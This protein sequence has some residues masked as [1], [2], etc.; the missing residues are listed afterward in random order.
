[1]R[2][3]FRDND[4]AQL[5]AHPI[6][7]AIN[8]G[9]LEAG[10]VPPPFVPDPRR[11][12]AKDLG[13]VGAFSSVRGVELDAGDAALGDAFASGTVPIPWQEELLETG[14]FQELDVW[15]PPGTLPPDLDPTKAPAGGGARSATCGVL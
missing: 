13:E 12:Y 3:G 11:V 1:T 6:F 7:A 14:L 5:K 4:C 9:R 10:L 2:L 15:G 8:W